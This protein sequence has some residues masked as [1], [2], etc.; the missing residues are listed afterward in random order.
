M[1]YLPAHAES[2]RNHHRV[3]GESRKATMQ[4]VTLLNSNETSR[5][6]TTEHPA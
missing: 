5:R 6:H 4:T 1:F 2:K 3:D